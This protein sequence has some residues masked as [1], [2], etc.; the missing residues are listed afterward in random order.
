MSATASISVTALPGPLLKSARTE[1]LRYGFADANIGRIATAAGMSKKTIYKYVPSKE[2]LFLALVESVLSGQ[3][4]VLNIL[5]RDAPPSV[6]LTAYLKAFAEL[7]FSDEG[8][9]SYRLVTTEGVR[10]PDMART[11]IEMLNR[12]SVQVLAGELT[13]YANA[14]QIRISDAA[15]AAQM[16]LA[17]VVAAPLRDAALGIGLPPSGAAL[18]ERLTEVVQIFLYGV[19]H[20]MDR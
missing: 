3:S 7:A 15:A 20:P 11:Y 5:D 12:Y 17:M 10:F 8:I 18:D 4:L 2:A 14:G 6:R 9:T 1:F 16:L 19:N 13:V